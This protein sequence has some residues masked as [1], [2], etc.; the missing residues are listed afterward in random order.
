MGWKGTTGPMRLP[1]TATSSFGSGRCAELQVHVTEAT[2]TAAEQR[3]LIARLEQDLSTIQSIQR[4]DA[5]VSPPPLSC[6]LA[7]CPGLLQPHK[8]LASQVDQPDHR[9]AGVHLPPPQGPRHHEGPS[10]DA[11][12]Q[13]RAAGFL[14]LAQSL[15]AL[16]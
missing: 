5:E 16:A 13:G 14:E 6:P 12:P 15:Q 10:Q 3:E 7:T 9:A 8:M 11:R 2:T 4:P 1:L